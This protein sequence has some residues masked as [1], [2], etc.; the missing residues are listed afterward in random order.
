[1]RGAL[2][3]DDMKGLEKGLRAVVEFPGITVHRMKDRFSNPTSGGWRDCM[4]NVSFADDPNGVICE[5][6]LI[7]NKLMLARKGM[8]GHNDYVA[9]R[10]ALELQEAVAA[11]KKFGGASHDDVSVTQL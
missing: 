2:L 4:L 10:A 9:F 6:Q 8:A 1:M 3:F 11:K 7:H 5:V